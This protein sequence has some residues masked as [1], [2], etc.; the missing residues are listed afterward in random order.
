MKIF[1]RIIRRKSSLLYGCLLWWALSGFPTPVQAQ[2][3]APAPIKV[4]SITVSN[5]GPQSVS[6][7]LVRANIRI[8]EGDT[9]NRNSLDDDVRNLYVTGYFENI[10]VAEERRQEGIALMYIV[11]PR[12]KVTDVIFTGNKKY[13]SAKLLK[14]IN[15]IDKTKKKDQ[16]DTIGKPLDERQLFADALE[17]K[18]LYEKAG[19]PR[20]KVTP[21]VTPDERSGRATVTFEITEAPKIRISDV[22]FEGGDSF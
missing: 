16:K 12:L 10:R 6:E 2:A 3:Q 9:F 21:K 1:R 4:V 5:V 22:V 14:K 8:K 7:S 18:K 19:Y 11:W 17:I 20:T 15:S 13:S